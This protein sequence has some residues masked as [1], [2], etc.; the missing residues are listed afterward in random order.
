MI[1]GDG[2]LRTSIPIQSRLLA[3][4]ME[5]VNI[6][7]ITI[8]RYAVCIVSH[9]QLGTLY[10]NPHPHHDHADYKKVDQSRYMP[11][12]VYQLVSKYWHQHRVY[13]LA[14]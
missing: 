6:Y 5:N 7:A 10:T 3:D 4:H 13:I 12:F 1:Y 2:K 8:N 14:A 11:R 9:Q